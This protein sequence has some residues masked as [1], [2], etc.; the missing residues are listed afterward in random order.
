MLTVICG[1][2]SGLR[3]IVTDFFRKE[4]FDIIEKIMYTPAD[5]QWHTLSPKRDA[6]EAA[7]NH[8]RFTYPSFGRTIGICDGDIS[9]ALCG[10]KNCL[11][12]CSSDRPEIYSELKAGYGGYVNTIFVYTD[13]ERLE[14]I[15]KKHCGNDAEEEIRRRVQL[16]G[17]LRKLY[18]EN[19]DLFDDIVIFGGEGSEFDSNS[20][21]RQLRNIIKK[22]L[23]SQD[24]LNDS[25]YVEFPYQGHEQYLFTS[26]SHNDRDT[27]MEDLTMLRN[28]GCRLW[29]D[30]AGIRGGQNWP[31]I[32]ADKLEHCAQV[33]LFWSRSSSVSHEVANEINYAINVGKPVLPIMIDDAVMTGGMKLRIGSLQYIQR[34]NFDYKKNLLHSISPNVFGK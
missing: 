20:V 10:K 28:H 19:I 3:E 11:L 7:I 33:L 8:C 25:A 23:E 4:N 22:S 24:K 31:D 34:A 29:Y 17:M 27:I 13:P 32:I 16:G 1:L 5:V 9:D 14:E 2:P 15:Y 26:Y 12:T 30:T 6:S 18:T 21:C